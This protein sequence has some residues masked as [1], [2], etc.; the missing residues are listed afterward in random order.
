[1]ETAMDVLNYSKVDPGILEHT[2]AVAELVKTRTSMLPRTAPDDVAE[3]LDRL[4][5]EVIFL[6]GIV[7]HLHSAI[8]D[9][10]RKNSSS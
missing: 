4:T 7:G 8:C 5:E 1:M 2:R 6:I 3:K 10:E 9:I